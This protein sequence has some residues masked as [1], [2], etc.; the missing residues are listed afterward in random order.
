M[1][2]CLRC[3]VTLSDDPR[4]CSKCRILKSESQSQAS[5][6][7]S[8]AV[9]QGDGAVAA[10][11]MG[12]AVGSGARAFVVVAGGNVS[13][14]IP[15]PIP[16]KYPSIFFGRK[17]EQAQLEEWLTGRE[18]SITV[19]QGIPGIGKTSLGTLV[20]H[21]LAYKFQ[22]G[23][24]W[25]DMSEYRGKPVSL[26]HRFAWQYGQDTG[27]LETPDSYTETVR[28]ILSNKKTLVV[29]DHVQ[30][31]QELKY[32]T[33]LVDV[34]SGSAML[35][36]THNE[37]ISQSLTSQVMTLGSLD[38]ESSILLLE[39][40]SGIPMDSEPNLVKKLIRQVHGRPTQ[41]VQ[42]GGQLK[43]KST[44]DLKDWTI[45]LSSQPVLST[46]YDSALSSMI[47]N[48]CYNELS[49][50]Q[51]RLLRLVGILSPLGCETKALATILERPLEDVTADLKTLVTYRL[52]NRGMTAEY[53]LE[54]SVYAIIRKIAVHAP[55]F[56]ELYQLS[57]EYYL[58]LLSSVAN[59]GDMSQFE[60]EFKQAKSLFQEALSREEW[61][62]VQRYSALVYNRW[63]EFRIEIPEESP[64]SSFVY[65]V[66][67]LHPFPLFH[68][69]ICSGTLADIDL[70][71]GRGSDVVISDAFV[72]HIN[73]AGTRMGDIVIKDAFVSNINLAGAWLGDIV[74]CDSFIANWDFRGARFGSFIMD[75]AQGTA[76]DMRS[77]VCEDIILQ[78]SELLEL[79]LQG[80]EVRVLVL[81]SESFVTVPD[82]LKDE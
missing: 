62:L 52:I 40:L 17:E 4:F 21:R 30:S 71:G 5:V 19:L 29:L 50:E 74:I 78:G 1:N 27:S 10:G 15:R 51:Q 48:H 38:Q 6:K 14:N 65:Q 79:R 77:A 42:I 59:L 67:P 80:A 7:D 66:G 55:D 61:H 39:E 24:L 34:N 82:R 69:R 13:I 37:S 49:Q 54:S 56:T 2:Q 68:I 53:Q 16:P 11:E 44:E 28:G 70:Q 57:H 64:S 72:S 26:L 63:N 23:C 58:S 35:V 47:L 18:E 20:A 33:K 3:G 46:D 31:V 25:A 8:G 12:V 22:D 75:H 45:R 36:I 60:I 32:F 43:D 9:A 76:V 41:L 73:L 81:E